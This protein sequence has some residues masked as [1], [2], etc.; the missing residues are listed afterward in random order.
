MEPGLYSPEEYRKDL[1][2]KKKFIKDNL[3]KRF[4]EVVI[5][6]YDPTKK[7]DDP[8][9]LGSRYTGAYFLSINEYY[10]TNTPELLAYG[11]S[12]LRSF[13]WKKIAT[14]KSSHASDFSVKNYAIDP[15]T[16]GLALSEANYKE[17]IT[18]WM[19]L[20]GDIYDPRNKK[21]KKKK[22]SD[23]KSI[24]KEDTLK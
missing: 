10:S 20:S 5:D 9:T 23:T 12:V 4:T 18:L 2:A 14:Y 3:I 13:G 17:T 11:Y 8:Y 15:K 19:K 24:N 6:D 22:D 7:C 1:A 21:K 16:G